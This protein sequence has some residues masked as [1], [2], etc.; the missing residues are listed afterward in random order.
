M[1]R[2]DITLQEC[3][4]FWIKAEKLKEL[5]GFY[6]WW[7]K[8]E[9]VDFLLDALGRKDQNFQKAVEFDSLKGYFEQK[10]GLFCI[11][12]GISESNLLGRIISNHINGSTNNS[13]LRRHL[14]YVIQNGNQFQNDKKSYKDDKEKLKIHIND[15]LNRL[16]VS[17]VL[18]SKDGLKQKETDL[19]NE[20]L[21]I[22]NTDKNKYAECEQA[23][24]I[25]AKMIELRNKFKEG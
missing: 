7:A 13:T 2:L 3:E 8:K 1:K 6:K 24:I 11:Y 21:H 12:V 22:L 23:E 18:H 9:D 25:R 19:I 20:K 15:F 4:A 5:P 10:N 14:G 17:C 16:T